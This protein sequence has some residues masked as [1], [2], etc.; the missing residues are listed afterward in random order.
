[1][2][3]RCSVLLKVTISYVWKFQLSIHDDNIEHG[4]V[5]KSVMGYRMWVYPM[6]PLSLINIILT[7]FNLISNRRPDTFSLTK[8][9]YLLD[10]FYLY[11]IDVLPIVVLNA[12]FYREIYQ[13]I[14]ISYFLAQCNLPKIYWSHSLPSIKEGFVK[15]ATEFLLCNMITQHFI[16]LSNLVPILTK[17]YMSVRI[18]RYYNVL[19]NQ[20]MYC[21]FRIR[22]KVK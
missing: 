8:V 13:N 17:L 14:V 12:V 9:W 20:S 4:L 19:I 6:F 11:I 16:F 22:Y 3:F 1:F 21:T 18:R 10:T 15:K 2:F 7:Y 5:D